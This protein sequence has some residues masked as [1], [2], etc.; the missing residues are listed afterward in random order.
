MKNTQLYPTDLTDRQWDCIKDLIPAAKPGGRPRTLE[1]RAVINAILYIVVSGCQW[2][3]LPREY[4][5]WQSVYTYA[6]RSGVM[7]ERGNGFT[8]RFEPK[9]VDEQ[10]V[11][12]SQLPGHWIAKA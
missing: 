2:R 5:A 11:I 10:V 9:S 7:M 12:S 4:P 8:T 1:M 3:M 6:S